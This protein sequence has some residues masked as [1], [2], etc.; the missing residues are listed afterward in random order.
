[1]TKE[2]PS[3]V[4]VGLLCLPATLVLI[5]SLT[6]ALV[7]WNF[8]RYRGTGLKDWIARAWWPEDR[9]RVLFLEIDN[10]FF[11][12]LE[13][14]IGASARVLPFVWLAAIPAY[15]AG[16]WPG[17]VATLMVAL[18]LFTVSATVTAIATHRVVR[19]SELFA[20]DNFGT[21]A[22]SRRDWQVH[23]EPNRRTMRRSGAMIA[24][25]C[26]ILWSAS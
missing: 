7:L 21:Y 10:G 11:V 9:R 12:L 13:L 6:V 22:R 8:S 3:T 1:M 20:Y 19:L 16:P 23:I 4:E 26:F 14:L 15:F 17:V 18:S 2:S 5:A 25:L 24:M